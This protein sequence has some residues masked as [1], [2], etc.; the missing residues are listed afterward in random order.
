MHQFISGVQRNIS[1]GELEELLSFEIIPSQVLD[2]ANMLS[3]LQSSSINVR[4]TYDADTHDNISDDQLRQIANQAS[5]K[6]WSKLA[7]AIG[8]LEYDIETYKLRNKNDP[9]ATVSFYFLF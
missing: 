1:A 6:N 3:S 8:F 7:L 4:H 5:R 9:S 2:E